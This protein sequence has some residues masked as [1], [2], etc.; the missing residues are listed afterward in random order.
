MGFE[1]REAGFELAREFLG[2]HVSEGGVL[3]LTETGEDL[4]GGP[5]PDSCTIQQP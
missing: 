2:V 4:A 5:G 3:N 1:G